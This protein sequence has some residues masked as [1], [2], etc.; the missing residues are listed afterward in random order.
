MK[1][2]DIFNADEF[3]KYT[4]GQTPPKGKV[5]EDKVNEILREILGN[6]GWNVSSVKKDEPPKKPVQQPK[7]QTAVTETPVVPAPPASAT[8]KVIRPVVKKA[9]QPAVERKA[10]PAAQRETTV[11]SNP[12]QVQRAYTQPQTVKTEM[13]KPQPKPVA[14]Q[15]AAPQPTEK[16]EPKAKPTVDN[17]KMPKVIEHSQSPE[18]NVLIVDEEKSYED[19]FSGE[20]L[21]EQE[22]DIQDKFGIELDEQTEQDEFAEDEKDSASKAYSKFRD[23]ASFIAPILIAFV[24]ALSLRLFV[25]SNTNVPT[26]SMMNTIPIGSRLIG[27]KL[28]YKFSDP[29]RF[30]VVIFKF[31]DNEKENYVKRIIGLPGETV[32]IR[33]GKVYINGSQTPLDDSFVTT[34][35]P[36]GNYGP[37]VVPEDSYFMLGD[38]RND[39]SD[40]R[41]WKNKFVKRDKIIAKVC[42]QYYPEFKKIE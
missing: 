20:N 4:S 19:F 30:D 35:V 15:P 17:G 7:T 28:T 3:S 8:K 29:Q 9:P 32:E 40:A 42:F 16:V 31:P 18:E 38:N 21:L 22:N 37:Y 25:F 11:K 10:E 26:G 6:Q 13:P 24:L 33:D 34:E 2:N 27:S 41:F 14:P 5:D 23:I 1:E 12:P 39:S 36:T